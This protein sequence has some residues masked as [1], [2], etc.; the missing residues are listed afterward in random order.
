MRSF[1][2]AALLLAGVLAGCSDPEDPPATHVCPDGREI[3]LDEVP[4]SN[5]T[6]FDPANACAPQKPTYSLTVRVTI[7]KPDGP[8]LADA[9]VFFAEASEV[10]PD[11]ETTLGLGY[12]TKSNGE[13]T[14]VYEEPQELILQ[15]FGPDAPKWTREGFPVTVGEQVI[16]PE[17]VTLEGRTVIVPLFR[18]ELP[19][20]ATGTW[21]P[22]SATPSGTDVTP[23]QATFAIDLGLGDPALEAAYWARASSIDLRLRWQ[24]ASPNHADMYAGIAWGD[25]VVASRPD[26]DPSD[27]LSPGVREATFTG[28]IPMEGRPGPTEPLHAAALTR[29]VVLG[30]MPLTF[31]GKLSFRGLV[32]PQLP[33]PACLAGAV[34]CMEPEL[35]LPQLPAAAA[36]AGRTA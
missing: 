18:R 8:T 25:T 6:G 24:N 15:L 14:V 3:R 13:F 35:P 34:E 4:G 9:E 12:Y 22:V 17:G 2:V 33:I 7:E 21:G 30:E 5:Q 11:D 27:L 36:P 28:P 26:N 10:R 32:P 16:V 23:A 31:T 19:F 1:V 29:T 20:T